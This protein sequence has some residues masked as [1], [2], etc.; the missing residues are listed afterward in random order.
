MPDNTATRPADLGVVHFIA[1]GGAGMSVVAQLLLDRGVQVQGSD[2]RDSVSLRQLAAQGVRT[3]VGHD[4]SHIAGADTIVVSSAIASDNVELVAARNQGLRVLHRSQALA[5]VM[6]DQVAI[7]V[8]GAHGKTTTSAMIAVVLRELGIDPSFAIG[9]SVRTRTG[10]ISG[11]H[12]GVGGVL[13]AEADE[14]DGSF[15]NYAPTISV[16]TNVEP[17]HLDHYGSAQAVDDIFALFAERVVPGGALV[18]CGDDAGGRRLIERV[19]QIL[20]SGGGV[21]LTVLTYGSDESNDVRLSEIHLGNAKPDAATGELTAPSAIIATATIDLG[22][23]A[24]LTAMPGTPLADL[25]RAHAPSSGARQVALRLSVP[26]EHN[27]RNATAALVTAV[28]LGADPQAVVAA[29]STF[30]G[31]GRRFDVRGDVGGVRVIDDYAHHPTE[32]AALLAGARSVVGDGRV[33]ALFQP[34]LYSRTRIFATEFARALEG[35]DLAI[36]CDVYGA[37]ELPDP[38]VGPETITSHATDPR[39]LWA[40]ADR[41]EAACQLADLARPGD[42]L[43][44]VGAGDVTQAADVVLDQLAKRFDQGGHGNRSS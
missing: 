1:L 4:A 42:V 31:A 11:G 22:Q 25:H 34:H 2:A 3:W 17:D 27:L 30:S 20:A 15:L 10:P 14:S 32:V 7:A 18:V 36:V 21:P 40:I 43:L 12:A 39:R 44:L 28:L 16:V 8:A 26:G 37:R 29:L 23:L 41:D 35:A 6:R 5:V 19:G 9:G 38:A 13:V 33:L 24:P